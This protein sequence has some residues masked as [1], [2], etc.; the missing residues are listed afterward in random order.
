MHDAPHAI[1]AWAAPQFRAQAVAPI[2]SPVQLT[3]ERYGKLPKSYVVCTKD[4]YWI[5]CC[6]GSWP[7][8]PTAAG[9]GNR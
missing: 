2:I 3:E 7:P 8:V 6:S 1:A 9:K 5:R 4:P